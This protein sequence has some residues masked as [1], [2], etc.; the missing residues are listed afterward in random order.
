VP[1]D[2]E[3]FALDGLQSWK[4]QK[5]LADKWM[6]SDS[7]LA[8]L[9]ANLVAQGVLPHGSQATLAFTYVADKAE[10]LW[11]KLAPFR[12]VEIL[13]RG[14]DLKLVVP[15]ALAG[16]VHLH[17]QIKDYRPGLG[18]MHFTPSRLKGKSVLRLWVEHL[19]LCA[20]GQLKEGEVSVLHCSDESRA[21]AAV[22]AS[23]ASTWLADFVAI[24]REG[25]QR[26]LPLF[27]SASYRLCSESLSKAEQDWE[28]G[29]YTHKG[30]SEDPY[31]QLAWRGCTGSPIGLEEHATLAQRVYGAACLAGLV[32]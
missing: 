19:A 31:I 1:E 26:P 18:L 32:P 10:S 29:E 16:E 23:Q 21:F 4:L 15:G 2:E 3:V 17:G 20:M 13:P 6:H 30:D 11:S 22:S 5:A 24:Y 27:P 25:M 28:G 9:Q 7:E 12:G 14:V 8:S